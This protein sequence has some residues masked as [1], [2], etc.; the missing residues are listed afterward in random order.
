VIKFLIGEAFTSA[1]TPEYPALHTLCPETGD[2]DLAVAAIRLGKHRPAAVALA[3]ILTRLSRRSHKAWEIGTS[4]NRLCFGVG[5]ERYL[6]LA[7]PVREAAPGRR[8]HQAIAKRCHEMS[9]AAKH[10][11]L[12]K[13]KKSGYLVSR[14][15]RASD[16]ALLNTDSRLSD[17]REV[18]AR[19]APYATAEARP[20]I[21]C[22]T[23]R[24][25]DD[26]RKSHLYETLGNS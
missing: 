4:I 5:D 26:G 16:D 24:W 7:H 20:P 19:E 8:A 17:Q 11:P 23:Y 15:A 25:S 6:R 10:G 14:A 2:P 21:S 12:Q 9:H 22:A 1:Y 13:K 18:E 3:G